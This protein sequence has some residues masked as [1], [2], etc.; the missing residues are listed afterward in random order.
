MKSNDSSYNDLG[1]RSS[2]AICAG[3]HC[4]FAAGSLGKWIHVKETTQ[5]NEG[6]LFSPGNLR[7]TFDN[8]KYEKVRPTSSYLDSKSFKASGSL[9]IGHLVGSSGIRGCRKKNKQDSRGCIRLSKYIDVLTLRA[10]KSLQWREE[11]QPRLLSKSGGV[12]L[13]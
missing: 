11:T 9:W 2:T 8:P 10:Q 4:G 5:I 12:L 6:K 3:A 13:T 7:A 1:N